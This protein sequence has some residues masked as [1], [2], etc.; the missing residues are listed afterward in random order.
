MRMNK[1]LCLAVA[2]AL[3]LAATLPA[4]LAGS[5]RSTGDDSAA[6]AA[7]AAAAIK[8]K[9]A[10]EKAASEAEKTSSGDKAKSKNSAEVSLSLSISKPGGL[11]VSGGAYQVDPSEV[12]AIVLSWSVKGDCDEYEVSVSGGVYSATTKKKSAKVSVGD[13]A[14]GKYTATVK[15]I[16]DGKAVAKAKL[17]FRV[18][19]PAPK[20]EPPAEEATTEEAPAEETPTEGT[21]AEEAPVEETPTEETPTE[22]TPTEETPAEESPG[23]SEVEVEVEAAED[24]EAE[25][26]DD[27]PGEGLEVVEPELEESE[28]AAD[29]PT[30]EGKEDEKSEEKESEEEKSEEEK[31]EEEKSGDEQS[32][33]QQGEGQQQG[34][35]KPSGG[36]RSSG[37]GAKGGGADA[38]QD[39]GFTI[40]PGEALT[41]THTSGDKDMRLYGAVTLALDDAAAMTCLTLDGTALDIRLSD[42]SPF[43]ASIEDGALALTPAGNA[44]A[45]LLNGGALKTLARSGIDTLKLIL[46]D[47]TVDF[48]T[49]PTLSGSN[50]AALRSAGWASGDYRYAVTANGV[51]LTVGDRTYALADTGELA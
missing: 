4:A 16:V 24:A 37:G 6:S 33:E 13:L 28:E 20:E 8:R 36:G 32:R 17:V 45:W 14:P 10:S 25:P 21:P 22:E 18:I 11:E 41:N 12:K 23:E 47:A 46:N 35:G 51:T 30:D 34:G 27:V 19:E 2:I 39:Q 1:L 49:Q 26:I 15:A 44:E 29:Q 5:L 50:Y 38:A 42:D 3:A 48:P 40:T 31:S 9:I 7:E 43:T